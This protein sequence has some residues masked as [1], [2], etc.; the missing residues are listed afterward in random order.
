MPM[1]AEPADRSP[2]EAAVAVVKPRLRG[3]LHAGMFPLALAAGIVLIALA[4]TT[5]RG[6]RP[7]SSRSPRALLF[8]TSRGLP[9]GQLVA[10][11]RRRAASAWTTPT[12]S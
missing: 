11:G 10:A 2:L 7:R 5:R 3:W 9:P 6:W 1:P 8:G 12:S 4:P